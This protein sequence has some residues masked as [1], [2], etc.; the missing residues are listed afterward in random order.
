MALSGIDGSAVSVEVDLARRLP[1]T[2]IVG[3]PGNAIRESAHRIRSAIVASGSEYPKKRVV[4]NLAPA[5]L[6]KVGT[7]FDLPIAIGILIAG[8]KAPPIRVKGTVFVG[9]LSLN[10]EL[11]AIKGALALALAAAKAGAQRI[12]LPRESAPEASV[13]QNIEVLAAENLH[14]VIHWLNESQDLPIASAPEQV[15]TPSTVDLREVRGQHGARRALEIAAAGGHN[16]LLLGPPGCGKTML[17]SRM[18]SILPQL[19]DQEA[20]EITRI[21][22][23]AGLIK[24]GEGLIST[25]PFRIPHHSI[26]NAG[27]M[28][29]ARLEP[30]EV[31]LAHQGVLFLDEIPEFRRSA[32]ELLRGPLE[33]REV[34]ISRARGFTRYPASFSLIA[35]AN[36]CPCGFFSHPSRPCVCTPS[37]VDRYRNKLSGPLMDRIDLQVWV[38]PVTPDALATDAQSECSE[39]VRKRVNQARTVQRN[40]FRG[41]HFSCNAE[42]QGDAIRLMS[43]P[44]SD[45]ITTLRE[46]MQ[47]FSLSGRSWARILKVSR[48]IADLDGSKQVHSRH[49]VES[50]SFRLD[51]KS[52]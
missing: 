34:R 25:R 40:R 14:D 35:A 24:P 13:G 50:S 30:G 29:N 27:L 51:P 10:G 37:Q 46:I 7:A 12:V 19:T 33:N 52:A 15:T 31:S 43:D 32:L 8:Q 3:L 9:E 39:S 2:I 44:S 42:L 1:A 23:V 45:A 38:Q 36:P 18:A 47:R 48:T 22:S 26:S 4:V 49:I 17:A 20:I 6:P 28:G 11:R 5:D 21:H 41:H 16:L